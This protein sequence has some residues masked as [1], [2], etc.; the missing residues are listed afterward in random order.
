MKL[1]HKA[2]EKGLS[3]SITLIPE[4]TEDMWHV[5]NLMAVGD[6]I[7]AS[8]FRK[9][10]TEGNT[11]TRQSQ[12]IR[13][14]LT[15]KIEDIDFDTQACLLRIKGRNIE[16]NE[17]VKMG[18]YHTIDVEANR[19]FTLSK[20]EWDTV[21]L[22]RVDEATDPSK[23]ADVAA[24]VMQEG[25]ANLVLISGSL[26][27]TRAKID[28][29]VPR[30]RRAAVQQHEKALN[31]FFDHIV[32]AILRHINFDIVKCILIASPGFTKD[33]FFEY[34]INWANK[35]PEGGKMLLEN[36]GKFVLVHASSGFKHSL[37]EVL[38]DPA[39]QSRLADTKATEEVRVLET[40]YKTLTHEP[41][42]A[43]Y[44]EK[45]VLRAAEAQAIEVLLISDK[46]F[47]AQD[48]A[49]R[50]VMVK[51]VDDV[52]EFG[53]EVKIFSSMHISG[54]QLEQLTGICAILRFPMQELEDSDSEDE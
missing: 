32:T 7:R 35:G 24:V 33:Q 17:H 18:A 25:L 34:M 27:L 16:E 3:G 30:K 23:N 51:L 54:E 2:I 21:S 31:R 11:G 52:R 48:V 45:H 13:L 8:T 38:Q 1:V 50:K 43:F 26:T 37:K 15:I 14:T 5:Y 9:I 46:L 42:K 41:L 4:E 40:F 36:K 29:S 12:K 28:I 44:G 39:L 6:S 22:E 20:V 47:R 19:K 49:K 53:G 10:T